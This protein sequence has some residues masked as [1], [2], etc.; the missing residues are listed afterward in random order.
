MLLDEFAEY[1][2]K[3]FRSQTAKMMKNQ[4][5]VFEKSSPI[6]YQNKMDFFL[7]TF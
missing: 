1:V 4:T 2:G 3:P 6:F 5:P 7:Y